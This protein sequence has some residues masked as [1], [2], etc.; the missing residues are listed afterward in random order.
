MPRR[1]ARFSA[2]LRGRVKL[3]SPALLV[4][5]TLLST[6]S[7]L[8]TTVGILEPASRSPQL[9]EASYRLQ[10]ELL[11]VGL[12]V[13]LVERP[14]GLAETAVG[15]RPQLERLAT[16]RDLDAILS[17]Q[18]EENPTS[19]HIWTFRRSPP[20]V[21]VQRVVLEPNARRPSET[22]AIRAIEALRSSFLELDLAE[23]APPARPRAVDPQL[24][25]DEPVP[26][27]TQTLARWG[28]EAGAAVASGVNGV[29]ASLSPLVRLDWVATPWLVAQATFAGLGTRPT[30]ET[31]DGSAEL[32]QTFG[33]VGLC[34]CPAS[35]TGIRPALSASAG[36]L[37]TSLDGRAKLPA[38][39]HFVARW[40][41]LMDAAVG[42]RFP[43]SERYYA[44]LAAHVQLAEPYVAVHF[45][46]TTVATT[47]RP[48]LLF[49]LTLGA[50]L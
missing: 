2:L 41:L 24:Q 38:R 50:W 36:A 45:A 12:E 6:G 8:A 37:R 27:P 47:G 35:T 15:S 19:V 46:D 11:A 43:L 28:L 42:A 31:E 32:A 30:L 29:G 1:L 4:T 20:R 21:E 5:F 33:L 3:A 10:G 7:A 17:V 18:G 44:T 48:N 22:L 40:S 9:T 49:T 25:L 16:E 13:E 39:G 23:R 14:P 26:P 34:Y